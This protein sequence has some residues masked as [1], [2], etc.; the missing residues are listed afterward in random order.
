MS[1]KVQ[2]QAALMLNVSIAASTK[3]NTPKKRYAS[4][5]SIA[6]IRVARVGA[7][8]GRPSIILASPVVSE[9]NTHAQRIRSN[10]TG[11]R[12]GNRIFL[13]VIF[14]PDIGIAP[15][16]KVYI[17]SEVSFVEEGWGPGFKLGG[18]G[19]QRRTRTHHGVGPGSESLPGT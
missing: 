18:P 8:S 17:Q 12:G 6:R 3:L 9:M 2:I 4:G 11:M 7:L 15:P 5:L 10:A 13:G 14:L 19:E 16:R 1:N